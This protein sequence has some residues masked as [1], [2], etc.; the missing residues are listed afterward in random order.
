[1]RKNSLVWTL[2]LLLTAFAVPSLSGS[3][4]VEA[5]P[6]A[7]E[8]EAPAAPAEPEAALEDLLTPEPIYVCLTNWCSSDLQCV[9]WHGP[10]ATCTKQPGATCGRCAL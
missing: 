9:K 5:L 4:P 7:P 3:E 1:M 2:V 8:A 10:G 6:A